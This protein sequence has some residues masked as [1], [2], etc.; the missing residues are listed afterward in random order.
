[1]K[2][3]IIGSGVVGKKIGFGLSEHGHDIIFHDIDPKTISELQNKNSKATLDLKKSILN[4]DVSFICVPTPT[5]ED[6]IDLTA[7]KQVSRDSGEAIRNKD[8]YHI[9]VVKSTIVPGTTEK[10]IIPLIER[11]SGKKCDVDF[12]VVYSPEFFTA[13]SKSWDED[14]H[15]IVIGEGNDKKAGDVVEELHKPLNLPIFRRNFKTAEFVKYA[16]NL[17]L[18]SKISAHNELFRIAEL[19]DIDGKDISQ[20]VILDKRIGKYGSKPGKGF[21]GSCF[22]KDLKAFVKFVEKIGHDGDLFREI[23]KL[24]K[25]MI[26]KYGVH[27]KN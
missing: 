15:R 26:E 10:V 9:F 11:H 13:S 22:P 5:N 19:L 2:V 23:E 21:S 6:G 16:A 14:S 12:G 17:T 20:M 7:I 3:S 25:K 27:E 8:E 1:M 4:S 18:I 24:N